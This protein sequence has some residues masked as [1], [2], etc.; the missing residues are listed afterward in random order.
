MGIVD[1]IFYFC[2]MQVILFFSFGLMGEGKKYKIV[3]MYI[4]LI[5]LSPKGL[6]LPFR[7][8]L[9]FFLFFNC[10]LNLGVYKHF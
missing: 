5:R 4:V 3:F 7:R 9:C 8:L 6:V 10:W 2:V 1:L